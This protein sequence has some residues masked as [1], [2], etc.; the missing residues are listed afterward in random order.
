MACNA[1]TSTN[2]FWSHAKPSEKRKVAVDSIPGWDGCYVVGGDLVAEIVDERDVDGSFGAPCLAH[3]GGAFGAGEVLIA[4]L[5]EHTDQDVQFAAGGRQA[6]G[7]A[8]A[9]T[10]FLVGL[11]GHHAVLDEGSQTVGQSVGGQSEI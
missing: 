6:V 7:R 2:V 11:L 5:L 4:P 9:L 3:H 8:P 1:V 10:G